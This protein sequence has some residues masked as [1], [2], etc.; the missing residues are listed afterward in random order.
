VSGGP[1]TVVRLALVD[2]TAD[3]HDRLRLRFGLSAKSH[4]PARKDLAYCGREFRVYPAMRIADAVR[5]YAALHAHWEAETLAADLALAG[6]DERFEI[7]RMKRTYQRA[8]VLAIAMAARPSQL[9]LEAAEEFDDERA[10]ALLR[11]AIARVPRAIVTYGG[12]LAH[13]VAWYDRVV[14]A[15]A[16]AAGDDANASV[17]AADGAPR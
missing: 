7:K 10:S 11:S 9:V 3:V 8:L 12:S 13:D 15:D 1:G 5:F 6:L 2:A 4:R 17:A 16:Y 14:A